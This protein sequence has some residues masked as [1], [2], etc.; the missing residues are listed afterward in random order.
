MEGNSRNLEAKADKEQSSP[1]GQEQAWGFVR[2]G[3]E[4]SAQGCGSGRAKDQGGAVDDKSGGECAEQE[5]FDAGF[6]RLQIGTGK[7]R[8]HIQWDGQ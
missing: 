7:G 3:E 4:D 5:V 6:F 1:N 8:Q 2:S